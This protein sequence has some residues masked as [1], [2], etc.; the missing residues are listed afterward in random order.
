[1]TKFMEQ[2]E[3]II[4]ESA[5][6]SKKEVS[7]KAEYRVSCSRG[8]ISCFTLRKMPGCWG[9]CISQGVEVLPDFR[10]KGIGT[11]LN[12]LRTEIAKEKFGTIICTVVSTN[13]AQLR[14]MKKTG[15]LKMFE[16]TNPNS[17]NVVF[18]FVKHLT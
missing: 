17:G 1:M 14:I 12:N 18:F 8:L 5:H 2:I 13:L 4:G 3:A 7:Y 15:W 10:G 9:I 16:T 6:L 11:I